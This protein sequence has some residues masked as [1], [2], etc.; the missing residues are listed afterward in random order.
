MPPRII[1][2]ELKFK[3]LTIPE[4]FDDKK[5]A[6]EIMRFLMEH[7]MPLPEIIIIETQTGELH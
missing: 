5:I 7:N 6:E 4:K 1:N 2:V 3:D